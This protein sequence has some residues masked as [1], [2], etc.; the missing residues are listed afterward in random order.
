MIKVF[1]PQDK[2][3]GKT[4]VRGLWINDSGKIFY[5]YLKISFSTQKHYRYAEK[6]K[7][8]NRLNYLKIKY[9]QE[10]IFYTYNSYNDDK[11]FIY[12]NYNKIEVLPKVIRLEIGKDRANLKGLIKRLLRNY[13]GLTIYTEPKGYLLE[14][15][16]K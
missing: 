16:Y 8:Y 14:V 9:N 7:F 13:K 5:D 10:A 1:I 2:T 11:G 15:Y 6:Q 4:N 3:Q 12:Y